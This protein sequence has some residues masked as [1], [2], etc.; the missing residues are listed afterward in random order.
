MTFSTVEM[1]ML[2]R[3][4]WTSYVLATI[5][6]RTR[7]RINVWTECIRKYQGVVVETSRIIN[8]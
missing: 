4:G 2:W 5:E 7:V 3:K 1:V 6:K 8:R